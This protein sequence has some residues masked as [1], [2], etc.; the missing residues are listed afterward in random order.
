LKEQGSHAGVDE[1][2][3]VR[4]L[5]DGL[6]GGPLD[7]AIGIVHA[8][9]GMITNFDRVVNMCT[10][11]VAVKSPPNPFHVSALSTQGQD[12][13]M[14]KIRAMTKAEAQEALQAYTDVEVEERWHT[15]HEYTPLT[16]RQKQKLALLRIIRP[17]NQQGGQG[18]G[19]GRGRG[20]GHGRGGR[21]GPGRGGGRGGRGD[22]GGGSKNQQKKLAKLTK[23][24]ASLEKQLADKS[25]DD[26][27][28][29][30]P[31][32]KQKLPANAT[33]PNLMRNPIQK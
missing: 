15:G 4:Y 18:R 6:K 21:G 23:Q 22:G 26:G 12:D 9:P 13:T 11:M 17:Q 20:R 28:A 14:Q 16:D 2:S 3:K 10:G 33:N 1:G 31:N 25:M 8:T 30:Q 27:D 19:G 29:E 24:V 32:K 7:S 5:L